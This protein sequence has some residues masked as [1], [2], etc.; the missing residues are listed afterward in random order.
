MVLIVGRCQNFLPNES[1]VN[2]GCLGRQVPDEVHVTR[3]FWAVR[4][5]VG[6]FAKGELLIVKKNKLKNI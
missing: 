2:L 6:K 5:E 4:H 1:S 3:K